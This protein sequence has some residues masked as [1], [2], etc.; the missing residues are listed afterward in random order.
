M[1][2]AGVCSS[3]LGRG[4]SKSVIPFRSA[5]YRFLSCKEVPEY[6]KQ[7]WVFLLF[8]PFFFAYSFF[9]KFFVVITGDGSATFR[10]ITPPLNMIFLFPKAYWASFNDNPNEQN[11]AESH[12]IC[13]GTSP[14]IHSASKTNFSRYM[15]EMLATHKSVRLRGGNGWQKATLSQLCKRPTTMDDTLRIYYESRHLW[16]PISLRTSEKLNNLRTTDS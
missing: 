16:L 4:S 11:V 13:S 7:Q 2:Y 9:Q 3:N 1:G 8:F 6:T 15:W 5:F 12:Q 10:P 14:K